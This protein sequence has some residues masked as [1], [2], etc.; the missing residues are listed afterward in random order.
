MYQNNL[1]KKKKKI[2]SCSKNFSRVIGI[3]RVGRETTA[4]TQTRVSLATNLILS[5]LAAS[6]KRDSPREGSLLCMENH[7]HSSTLEAL[8][9]YEAEKPEPMCSPDFGHPVSCSEASLGSAQPPQATLPSWFLGISPG[10][11]SQLCLI[12]HG[13]VTH[14][15]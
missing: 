3:L 10:F 6:A 11:E 15:S 8:R 12:L 13:Q 14:L 7:V 5:F 1:K 9:R 4:R 2:P